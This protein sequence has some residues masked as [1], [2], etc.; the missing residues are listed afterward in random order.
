MSIQKKLKQ[1]YPSLIELNKQAT[2]DLFDEKYSW[3]S[4]DD[5]T[6]IGIDQAEL[7]E[8]DRGVLATFL[9]PFYWKVP[10]RTPLADRWHKR[11]FSKTDEE[12][13]EWFRFIYFSIEQNAFDHDMIGNLFNEL[14]S[15]EMPV[16]WLS[17]QD[18][19][20]IETVA[21][22]GD[23]MNYHQII[24]ILIADVS[25]T[26]KFFI[27]NFM[28]SYIG[29]EN[30][31][32]TITA[33][34]KEIFSQTNELV[35]DYFQSIPY[36]LLQH[37]GT[38]EKE[39][40][41]QSVLQH[42]AGDEEM[43]HTLQTFLQYNLNVSETAKQLFMHRNSLQYRID[44]FVSETNIHIQSFDQAFVVQLALIANKLKEVND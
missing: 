42:F 8:K 31:L 30:Y 19:I 17:H 27:G 23:A 16:I 37:V 11:I 1:L 18:G 36:L 21:A 41:V 22:Q 14:F 39:R 26:I 25:V 43:L 13:K 7:N 34:G 28:H 12:P 9:Q 40:L 44:K 5:T 2:N 10:T 29:L 6:I 38:I 4:V 3:F 24:D 15:D 32:E 35:I 33:Q 20:L